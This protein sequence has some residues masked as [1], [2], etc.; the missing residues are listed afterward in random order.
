M[1]QRYLQHV[2]T[3][4]LIFKMWKE[5]Q[6]NKE[7]TKTIMGKRKGTKN[8]QQLTEEQTTDSVSPVIK[9]MQ[10]TILMRF[11]FTP[12]KLTKSLE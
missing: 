7:K 9:K 4:G 10:I 11:Y 12:L 8:E 1:G 5:L 6:V 2:S 3:I